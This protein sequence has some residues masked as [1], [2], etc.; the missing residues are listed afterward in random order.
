LSL[1]RACVDRDTKAQTAYAVHFENGSSKNRIG[2]IPNHQPHVRCAKQF[3]ELY[4]ASKALDIVKE[5]IIQ[6]G[7]PITRVILYTDSKNTRA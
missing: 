2:L 6:F 7:N 3:A 1:S 5:L 4:A